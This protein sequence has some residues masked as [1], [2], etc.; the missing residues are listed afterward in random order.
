MSFS[1]ESAKMST[2][3]LVILTAGV[4]NLLLWWTTVRG[5]PLDFQDCSVDN[6]KLVEDFLD[7]YPGHT[8]VF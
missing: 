7:F 2:Q 4:Q 5:V 3:Q 8:R 1:P 6:G